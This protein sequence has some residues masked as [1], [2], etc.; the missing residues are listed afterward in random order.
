MSVARNATIAASIAGASAVVL[1]AFG[2][3]ALQ[4]TLTTS[5]LAAWHTAVEYQFWH[6]LALLGVAALARS[7]ASVDVQSKRDV[8][9]RVA[10]LA[11][12]IGIVSFCGSLY[13]LALGAPRIVGIVT[14]FG[15]V[16]FI[17]GWIAIAIG[18]ARERP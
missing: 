12:A 5:A 17:V 4:S 7:A 15:G 2:A 1:G 6:A 18:A 14:P 13:A 8:A 16:A 10:A 11:F 9:V 3:H